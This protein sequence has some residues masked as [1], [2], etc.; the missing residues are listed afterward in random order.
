M[1][2]QIQSAPAHTSIFENDT[3]GQVR[4]I[5][6][7]DGQV[8]FVARD[9]ATALGYGNT[10]DAICQHV[11]EEDRMVAKGRIFR[12]LHPQTILINESGLYALI[13][14][15]HKPA[16]KQFKR[17][18]TSEILP[19]IRRQGHRWCVGN[20]GFRRKPPRESN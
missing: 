14:G 19:T 6:L 12:P 17:W 20:P 15:S 7:D 8:W 4:A 2:L 11:E 5:E 10:N 9:V 1:T 16:A 13:F 18:V 3:F